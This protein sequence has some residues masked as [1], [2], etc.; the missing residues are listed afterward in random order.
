MD[1]LGLSSKPIS[2]FKTQ[3]QIAVHIPFQNWRLCHKQSIVV[4]QQGFFTPDS[5]VGSGYTDRYTYRNV[6]D[7]VSIKGTFHR[8]AYS[9]HTVLVHSAFIRGLG[10]HHLQR[11]S[12]NQITLWLYSKIPYGCNYHWN[13]P[14]SFWCHQCK[15]AAKNLK[16]FKTGHRHAF[17]LRM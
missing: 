3:Q 12:P 9:T 5:A 6:L 13:T 17:S 1:T 16:Q 10:L 7:E 15:V 11:S 4:I 8:V 14:Y 2:I